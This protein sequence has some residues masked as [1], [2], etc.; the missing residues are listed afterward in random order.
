MNIMK[1]R[2]LLKSISDKYL[3]LYLTGELQ[4]ITPAHDL[5]ALGIAHSS[6]SLSPVTDNT[7]QTIFSI[8]F[9]IE[10]IGLIEILNL[11]IDLYFSYQGD[12]SLRFQ[13][14]GDGGNNWKT[15]GENSFNVG[16]MTDGTISG[17]GQWITSIQSGDNKLRIRL[18][19]L[20]NAGVVNINLGS[21]SNIDLSYRKKVSL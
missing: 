3:Q 14:S 19:T 11:S 8:S 12:G 5:N 13:I 1:L 15:V 4:D 20:A 10:D 9:T 17:T 6:Y 16:V 18:Q 7:Y 2:R 21:P